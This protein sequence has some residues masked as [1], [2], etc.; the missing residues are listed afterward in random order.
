MHLTDGEAAD[1]AYYLLRETKVPAPLEVARYRGRIR[2]LEELDT[3][4]LA[5][6]GAATNFTLETMGR[7]RGYA[8]RFS[9]WL[10]VETAGQYTFHFNVAGAGRLSVD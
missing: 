10:R 3:T 5:G 6:T 8:L 2:S 7:D 4:E 1:L 9:G